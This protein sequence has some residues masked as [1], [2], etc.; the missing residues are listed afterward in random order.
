[1]NRSPEPLALRQI[2]QVAERL[3]PHVHSTPLMRCCNSEVSALIGTDELHLK[4]EFLQKT[5]SFK[6][7]GA[8]NNVLSRDP[9]DSS[10]G[11]T[12]VSA[13]NHAIAVAYAAQALGISAKVLMPQ[14]ASPLRIEK[15]AH[16]GAEVVCFE[17]IAEGFE[18]MNQIAVAEDRT[19]VHPFDGYPTMQGTATVGLEI[20]NLLTEIDTVVVAVGGGGL[21][22][23]VGAALK[24]IHPQIRVIGVEPEGAAGMTQSLERGSPLAHVSVD[25]IAD[26]MGAP[27]HC[28]E[29]FSVCQRVID[30]MVL[31]DDQALCRAMAL[32]YATFRFALEPA[33]VAVIAALV[34]PLASACKGRR[35]AAVLCGSNIDE[36]LWYQFVRRGRVDQ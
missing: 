11:V 32:V 23:G 13:G 25:T 30:Q 34:G 22:A 21:I 2:R 15:C 33:G 26:S 9:A 20:G 29:S 5:G 31:V 7:R 4:L 10:K 14:K 36:S 35:I 8:I 28:D 16:Y 3:A 12:A 19:I 1:M 27:L 17:D 6:A 24:Q 18:R